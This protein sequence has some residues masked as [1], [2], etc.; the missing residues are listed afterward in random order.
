[1]P[2]LVMHQ[3]RIQTVLS[4]TPVILEWS[5]CL[6]SG[7]RH[8]GR[9]SPWQSYVEQAQQMPDKNFGHDVLWRIGLSL[10]NTANSQ[11]LL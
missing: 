4:P 8:S 6:H 2:F 3:I 9:G 7:G 10:V 5:P 11:A 1:M